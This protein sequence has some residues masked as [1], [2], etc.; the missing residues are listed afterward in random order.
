MGTP[1]R[2]QPQ[3][4]ATPRQL[5]H[6]TNEPSVPLTNKH[7]SSLHNPINSGVRTITVV[8]DACSATPRK[9]N[10]H[11]HFVGTVTRSYDETKHVSDVIDDVSKT[12]NV[13]WDQMAAAS[14]TT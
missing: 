3:A 9:A 12:Y 7:L 1:T 13:H 14:L 2:K 10:T 8:V 4:I 6:V 5:H 11:M